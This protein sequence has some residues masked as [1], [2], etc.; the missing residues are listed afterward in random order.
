MAK[1]KRRDN[2]S[3]VAL[4]RHLANFIA[5]ILAKTEI[6]P[7]VVTVLNSVVFTTSVVY[8]LVQ[9]RYITNLIALFIMVLRSIFD[10]VDGSLARIKSLESK[11]GDWLDGSLDVVFDY[12]V[13]SATIINVAR[14]TEDIKWFSVGLVMLVGRGMANFIGVQYE[15]DF[16]FAADS[17]S[18]EFNRKFKRLKKISPLDSFLKNIIVPSQ[19]IYFFFFCCRYL[20]MLGILF[21]RLDIFLIIFATTI[22]IRWITMYFLYLRYLHGT[23]SKLYTVKFLVELYKYK[24]KI[25]RRIT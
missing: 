19:F 16:G 17:G 22:N 24:T 9:G 14:G 12:L 8:F 15:R 11:F 7:N 21:N 5:K 25:N 10:L 2:D 1:E 13:L 20:L 4:M 3:S 23:E 18:R 6:T